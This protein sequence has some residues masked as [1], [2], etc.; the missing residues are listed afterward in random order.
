MQIKIA[1]VWKGFLNADLIVINSQKFR[2]W[3]C[4]T[5]SKNTITGALVEVPFRHSNLALF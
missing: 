2:L 5:C 4:L 3:L 1:E